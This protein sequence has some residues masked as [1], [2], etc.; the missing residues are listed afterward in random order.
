MSRRV[1]A[2]PRPDGHLALMW[3]YNDLISMS[4]ADFER[5]LADPLNHLHGI[6]FTSTV[7]VVSKTTKYRNDHP[8]PRLNE[9]Q[10]S[11][12]DPGR[13]VTVTAALGEFG[14]RQRSH[15]FAAN[16]LRN[17][18]K[19]YC[20]SNRKRAKRNRRSRRN[21][22]HKNQRQ[23]AAQVKVEGALMRSFWL[24]L[25]L[26][27]HALPL[28][29][30]MIQSLEDTLLEEIMNPVHTTRRHLST[31]TMPTNNTPL[32][33]FGDGMEGRINNPMIKGNLPGASDC[34]HSALKRL[35]HRGL[36]MVPFVDKFWP[37]QKCPSFVEH[38]QAQE[39][40]ENE[41]EDQAQ[42]GPCHHSQTERVVIGG[43]TVYS[44][45]QCRRCHTIF[46]RN[47]MAAENLYRQGRRQ[48]LGQPVEAAFSRRR[49][50]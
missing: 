38:A 8:G 33:M 7:L 22:R 3:H 11:A 47:I 26:P 6:S 24:P 12:V 41:D 18:G 17:G 14:G 40:S 4:D 21:K 42:I 31:T 10:V 25:L 37:S 45:K 13:R 27:A 50:G 34:V 30:V 15:D 20:R 23:R 16:V 35:E 48:L 1:Y 19:K 2:P 49:H 43:A 28:G 44:L 29:L 5:V 9:F 36:L 32:I 39:G 46:D